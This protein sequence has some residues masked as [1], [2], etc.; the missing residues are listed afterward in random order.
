MFSVELREQSLKMT[1]LKKKKSDRSHLFWI[2][3]FKNIFY[4]VLKYISIV[5]KY[6]YWY[7]SGGLL[8]K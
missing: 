5:T 8:Q 1:D 4:Y 2:Q 3:V 7:F 6:C